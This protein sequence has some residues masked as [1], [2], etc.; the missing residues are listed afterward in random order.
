MRKIHDT[1]VI[2][3]DGDSVDYRYTCK[4]CDSVWD[5]QDGIEVDSHLHK[6]HS[7]KWAGRSDIWLFKERVIR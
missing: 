7:F 5:D 2:K 1:S 4:I 3:E 6:V